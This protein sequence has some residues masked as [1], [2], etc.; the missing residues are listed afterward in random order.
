MSLFLCLGVVD[1]ARKAKQFVLPNDNVPRKHIP[2]SI[3]V[4][5]GGFNGSDFKGEKNDKK[6]RGKRAK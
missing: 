3:I 6:L 5:S 1:Y 2:F 4:I